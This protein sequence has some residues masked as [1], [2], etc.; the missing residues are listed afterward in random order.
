MKYR[1]QVAHDGSLMRVLAVLQV[2]EMM[3]PGMGAEI[4][5]EVW[6]I[7]GAG[8]VVR[9]LWGGQVLK[10]S[11]PVLGKM[12]MIPMETVVGYLEELVGVGGSKVLEACRE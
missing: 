11:S 8:K 2:E 4:V 1:H 12:D 10:S 3:W 5:F 7:K 6:R 9:V